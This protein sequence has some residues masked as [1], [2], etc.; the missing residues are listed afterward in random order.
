MTE[1]TNIGLI[2][3]GD[4]IAALREV[5]DEFGVKLDYSGADDWSTVGHVYDALLT[6]LSPAEATS[7]NTW[8]RFAAAICKET[9]I[10]PS[11][12]SRDSGLIAEDG[13]WVHVVNASRFVWLVIV[14]GFAALLL[15]AVQ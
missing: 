7:S 11:S 12:I 15:W 8:D 10:S 6:Q 3:D 9:G 1:Q 14:V 5:E 2:G 4:E 13:M